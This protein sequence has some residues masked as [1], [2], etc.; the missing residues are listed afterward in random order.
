MS[1]STKGEGFIFRLRFRSRPSWLTASR[2]AFQSS[3]GNRLRTHDFMRS[4]FVRSSCCL[5]ESL[6]GSSIPL[7][8]SS[9]ENNLRARLQANLLAE[10]PTI[11][12]RFSPVSGQTSSS[13][14]RISACVTGEELGTGWILPKY[15]ARRVLIRRSSLRLRSR[16]VFILFKTESVSFCRATKESLTPA[17]SIGVST[18]CSWS[19][20][21]LESELQSLMGA[22]SC[23]LGVTKVGAFSVSLP[24]R[25]PAKTGDSLDKLLALLFSSFRKE[26]VGLKL[27]ASIF[28]LRPSFFLFIFSSQSAFVTRTPV[29]DTPLILRL[30]SSPIETNGLSS[31]G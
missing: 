4:I 24:S 21:L 3:F 13:E 7:I 14:E 18:T 23:S 19:D 25:L 27:P 8:R 20:S 31:R 22:C 6:W 9:S 16:L 2:T 28:A 26:V 29:Q 5:G 1:W 15:F 10:L 17:V 12:R 30:T 11:S